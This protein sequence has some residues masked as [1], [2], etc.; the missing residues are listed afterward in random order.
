MMYDNGKITASIT[1][2]I[3]FFFLKRRQPACRQWNCTFHTFKLRDD[4]DGNNDKQEPRTDFADVDERPGGLLVGVLPGAEEGR[5]VLS[6]PDEKADEQKGQDQ[7]HFVDGMMDAKCND[8]PEK[9][10]EQKDF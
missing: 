4:D 7:W 5:N 1:L 6:D 10:E 9:N 8:S 2:N 3:A